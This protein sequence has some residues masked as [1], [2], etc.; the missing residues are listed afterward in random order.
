MAMD[1]SKLLGDEASYLL[2]HKCST[3]AAEHLYL[4]GPDF[5]ERVVA[6]SDRP[7]PVMRNLQTMWNTGRLAGSGYLSIL[8]V[9]RDRAHCGCF[10]CAK[11]DLFRPG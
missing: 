9:D 6:Q 8:P 3:I 4:P 11:P 2:E 1:Y 10:F 7:I 5:A